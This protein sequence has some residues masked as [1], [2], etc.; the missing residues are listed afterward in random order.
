MLRKIAARYLNENLSVPIRAKESLPVLPT[1]RWMDSPGTK[2]TVKTYIFTT[3]ADRDR[4]IHALLAYEIEKG[5]RATVT[6]DAKNIKV[7]LATPGIEQVTELDR[8]YSRYL[9]KLYKDIY[10]DSGR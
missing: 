2:S 10:N 1:E 4:F 3:A 7:R 8:E 6:F 5:H 9:D